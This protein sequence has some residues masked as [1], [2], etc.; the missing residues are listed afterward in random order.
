MESKEEAT[1]AKRGRPSRSVV[2]E[3]S[4]AKRGRRKASSTVS[5]N[6]PTKDMTV[7]TLSD[8]YEGHER[9]SRSSEEV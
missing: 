3:A 7:L 8:Y 4:K 9:Q 1:P 6:M 5:D 2:N